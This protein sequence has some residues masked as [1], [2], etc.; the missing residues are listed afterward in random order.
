MGGDRGRCAE[1]GYIEGLEYDHII[2]I[3]E[4]GGNKEGTCNYSA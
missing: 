1:Y 2:P 3:V 4:G